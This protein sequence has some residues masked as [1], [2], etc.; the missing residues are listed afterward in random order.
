MS[1]R[2][3]LTTYM[4]YLFV[5]EIYTHTLTLTFSYISGTKIYTMCDECAES[6]FDKNNMKTMRNKSKSG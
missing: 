3:K 1:T 4:F 6:T 5:T 2:L